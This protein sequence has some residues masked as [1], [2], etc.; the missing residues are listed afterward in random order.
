MYLYFI[1]EN[2][3]TWSYTFLGS[4]PFCEHSW[5]TCRLR[6]QK[7]RVDFE[8]LDKLRQTFF[9]VKTIIF[10]CVWKKTCKQN[11]ILLI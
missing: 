5:D 2:S 7:S 1:L 9:F 8:N 11:L 10:P 6:L 3:R 4:L